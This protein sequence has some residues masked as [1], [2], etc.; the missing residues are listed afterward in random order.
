MQ[1]TAIADTRAG[2]AATYAATQSTAYDVVL[3]NVMPLQGFRAK[4]AITSPSFV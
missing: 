1:K 2:Q 3:G 4:K